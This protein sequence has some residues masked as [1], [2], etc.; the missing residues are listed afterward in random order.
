MSSD[1]ALEAKKNALHTAIPVNNLPAPRSFELPRG[2]EQAFPVPGHDF[3]RLSLN[4]PPVAAGSCP[5]SLASPRAC[6]FGGA[7]HT[8]PVHVQ[9]KLAVNRPGDAYE[10]EADRMADAITGTAETPVLQ[11]KC[12]RCHDDEGDELQRKEAPGQAPASELQPEALA[13]VHDALQS[14]GRPLEPT[15]REYMESRFDRDFSRVRV[16]TGPRASESARSVNA[17]AYT[18]GQDIVFTEGAYS[19]QSSSGLRLLAHE[20]THTVQQTPGVVRRACLDATVCQSIL[21]PMQL[22]AQARTPEVQ[23][24]RAQREQAC[25][26]NPQAAAC[27]AGGHADRAT[28]VEALLRGYDPQRMRNVQGIFVDL[29]IEGDFGAVTTNCAGFTPPLAA[30]GQC[31]TVPRRMED[32]ARTFNTTTGPLTIGG[33]ERGLWRERTLEIL[34]HEAG[35]A[36]FRTRFMPGLMTSLS[37]PN[38]SAS[39]PNIMGRQR[40]TC[41]RDRDS[42]INVFSSA[43]ELVAMLQEFPLRMEDIRTNVS[44]STPKARNTQLEEWRNHR[45][46]GT[47]QSIT[48]S[49]R[50]IRCMCD[51]L[52]ANSIIREA[53]EFAMAS[54]T[55]SEKDELHDEM[56]NPIWNSLDLRWPFFSST[57]DFGPGDYPERVL[58][59]GMAY[60]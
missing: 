26:P 32:N 37:A 12:A 59:P 38:L 58:P 33:M 7:C 45:I 25:T 46:R 56:N 10:Q 24:R 50:V 23:A 52:D 13:E 5:M 18:V 41:G 28:E 53:I 27:R 35:H 49:L 43:N 54:W 55:Q 60:A 31:I 39:A 4:A 51:C 22:L 42:R 30:S 11:R 48:N 1:A 40:P 47:K 17:L 29:D 21:T 19:P 15:A 36:D 20:L 57:H 2:P 8:C 44:F 6:P 14:P 9:T 16:H 34:V 3:G